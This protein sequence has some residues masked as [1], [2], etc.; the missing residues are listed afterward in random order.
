MPNMVCSRCKEPVEF[1][2]GWCWKHSDRRAKRYVCL[3]C[4]GVFK[5]GVPGEVLCD[6]DTP[7]LEDAHEVISI[8]VEEKEHTYGPGAS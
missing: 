6:C 7:L 4:G 5:L 3:S 2:N 8:R 1:V